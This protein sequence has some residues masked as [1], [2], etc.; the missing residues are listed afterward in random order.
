[1]K[2]LICLFIIF[3]LP[4]QFS[5]SNPEFSLW[6]GNR[7]SK[8]HVNPQGGGIRSEFGWKFLRDASIFPIGNETIKRIYE[9]F[10]KEHYA[11]EVSLDF[12]NRD[13]SVKIENGFAY[14]FDF[15]LQSFRSHKTETAKRKLIPMQASLYVL[16]QPTRFLS[17]N[18]QKNFGRIVFQGQDDWMTTV[19]IDFGEFLPILR[20]GKFQ[21][22]FGIKDCDMTSFDRRVASVDGTSVLFAPD[23]SELG[24]E[25]NYNKLSLFDFTFGVFDSRKLHEVAI[26]GDVPIVLKHNPS[27]V[28]RIVFY[29]P[30]ETDLLSFSFLGGSAFVN[31]HFNYLSGFVDLALRDNLVFHFEY[32]TSKVGDFRTTNNFVARVNYVLFRGL[33]PFCRFEYG[34]TDL[35]TTEL[36]S[37]LMEN[38]QVVGGV[39]IFPIPYLDLLFEYRFFQSLESKSLRWGFQLHLY[40]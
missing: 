40:Y 23:Y 27:F 13:S 34:R 33:I 14:G 28:G 15:R 37:W 12:E 9:I 29:P 20:F 5:F 16:L 31:G 7:C 11:K 2:Y 10:D 38:Y 21:P 1:M 30:I 4:L 24:F 18:A 6:T 35:K 25:I 19:G 8:C 17:I 39:K 32:I 22:T 36:T 26:F 3:S